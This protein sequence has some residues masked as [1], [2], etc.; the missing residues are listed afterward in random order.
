MAINFSFAVPGGARGGGGVRRRTSAR[1]RSATGAFELAEWTLGQR[2]VFQRNEDYYREGLP[3]LDEIV[4][5]VGQDPSVALLRLEAGEV[6]ILGDGIPPA[7]FVD[8]S[9]NPPPDNRDRRGWPAA[10]RLRSR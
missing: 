9:Q 3:K 10:H 2:L 5:E 4:F 6:D 7:R 8:V 1:T